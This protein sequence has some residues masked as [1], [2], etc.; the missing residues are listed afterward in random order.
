MRLLGR[1]QILQTSIAAIVLLGGAVFTPVAPVALGQ[2]AAEIASEK[3]RVFD[4]G[5]MSIPPEFKRAEKK[6]RIIQHEFKVGE[7]DSTARLTMMAAGGGIDANIK[8]WKGQ[9]SGGKK[10]DQ[11]S[12]KIKVGKTDVHLVDANGSYAE[13]MGGGPFFGGKKVQ[14][15]N[16]SMAAAIIADPSGRT[17]FLKL[18]GP[19][20][21]VDA[22]REKFIEMIKTL[23]K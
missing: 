10:E 6:S 8:R 17:Y 18:I 11:K 9:F 14:R 5:E 15:E 12:E 7:G 20:K 13:S 23:D 21:V 22:N 2:E 3:V 19:A 16:Y 1:R 4:I